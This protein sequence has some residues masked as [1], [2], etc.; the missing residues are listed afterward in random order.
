MEQANEKHTVDRSHNSR[1]A[2][3]W[4]GTYKGVLPCADCEGMETTLVLFAEGAYKKT[5]TYLGKETEGTIAKGNFE[6][7]DTGSKIKIKESTG[8]ERWYAVGEDVLFH[9]DN[10]GKRIQGDLAEK[11]VLQ[12]V[13]TD[14]KL[15]GKTWQLVELMG[16]EVAMAPGNTYPNITFNSE[17]SQAVGNNGCNRFM[18]SYELKSGNRIAFGNIASTL[19]ACENMDKASRF[20]EVLQEADNYAISGDTLLSLNKARMAPLARFKAQPGV[21]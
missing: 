6:W 17:R 15:E 16:E 3:D 2:L 7:D 21:E 9:L 20:N 8:S 10:T 14:S 18:G 5:I 12:K 4:V 19:M 1:N 13:I 11:Y